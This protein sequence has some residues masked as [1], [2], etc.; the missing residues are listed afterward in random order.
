[1]RPVWYGALLKRNVTFL[2][3]SGSATPIRTMSARPIA[4]GFPS[5]LASQPG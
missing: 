4:A 1:M 3:P 5:A 2:A